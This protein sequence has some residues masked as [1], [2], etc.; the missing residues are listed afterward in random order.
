[1][2]KVKGIKIYKVYFSIFRVNCSWEF[3]IDLILVI[4]L[5]NCWCYIFWGI[6]KGI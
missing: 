1:M 3:V 5:Y 4:K 6:F 2:L